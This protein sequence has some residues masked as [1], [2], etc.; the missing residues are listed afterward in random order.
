MLRVLRPAL[1][2]S[3]ILGTCYVPQT[4]AALISCHP[5]GRAITA[6][7]TLPRGT[8]VRFYNSYASVVATVGDRGPYKGKREFDIDCGLMRQLHIDGVGYVNTQ[9]L[10]R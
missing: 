10:G 2:A 8:R 1:L 6:H 5:Y 9:I 3:A 7:K 4:Q